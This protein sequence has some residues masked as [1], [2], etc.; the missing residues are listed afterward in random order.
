MNIL[1]L[2][3]PS[4]GLHDGGVSGATVVVNEQNLGAVSSVQSN[5]FPDKDLVGTVDVIDLESAV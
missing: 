5:Q 1:I 4:N 3:N 2:T